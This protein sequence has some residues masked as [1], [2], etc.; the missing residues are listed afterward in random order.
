MKQK[1]GSSKSS[2]KLASL[3][4][5]WQSEEKGRHKLPISGMKQRRSLMIL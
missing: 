3:L 2:I 4:E 5:D 1:T